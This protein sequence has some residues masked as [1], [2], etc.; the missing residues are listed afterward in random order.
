MLEVSKGRHPVV[1][2]QIG[3]RFVPND[4]VLNAERGT[5]VV[6]TGPNMGG[7]STYLRQIGLIT[8]MAQ[9]GSF[10][11]AAEACIG[12]AD[13]VFARL[14][15]SD[16]LHE[17][18]STFMVEM[19][20]AAHI[21][22]AASL[23]SLVLIDEL[24]RGTAT[25]DGLALAQSVVE[26]MAAQ[27]GCRAVFATHFHPLTTLAAAH[28]SIR[29]ISVNAVQDGSSVVF[30]HEISEG[31][32]AKSYGIEV[33][34]RAGLP[35]GVLRRADT[36]LRA[37]H[38]QEALREEGSAPEAQLSIFGVDRAAEQVTPS[39]EY[40][41]H[42]E[43]DCVKIRIS[44]TI[45]DEIRSVDVNNL[46]PLEALQRVHEWARQLNAQEEAIVKASSSE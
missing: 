14:G 21:L 19:R 9:A 23:R 32:A 33:A 37:I 4:I 1:M 26:W 12:I 46:T 41:E 7:K 43:N 42:V 5:F 8:I 30:T 31:P 29:N 16:D 13:R 18:E 28:A 38:E 25:S 17:G 39:E 27:I 40:T 20:E 11:P 45:C 36:L 35:A 44:D 15:A 10:V 2:R 3:K 34:R 24:G 6:L 22:R